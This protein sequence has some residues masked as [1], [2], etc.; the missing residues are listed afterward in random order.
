MNE[1]DRIEK[2]IGI[3][4]VLSYPKKAVS[5]R[6]Y[7]MTVGLRVD[8]EGRNW[9]YD[10]EEYAVHCFVD[11]GELFSCEPVGDASIILHRFKGTYGPASFFIE[12]PAKNGGRLSHHKACQPQWDDVE[13][14]FIR[15]N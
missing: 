12:S 2:Q 10:E 5:G 8:P 9:P 15:K 6:T 3:R 14:S 4:P 11:A 13:S 7:L 1:T